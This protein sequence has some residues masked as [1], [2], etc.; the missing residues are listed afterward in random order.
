M[1]TRLDVSA[2]A[3]WEMRRS[4]EVIKTPLEHPIYQISGAVRPFSWR[5]CSR[6]G[7]RLVSDPCGPVACA[8]CRSRDTRLSRHG[9]HFLILR[10]LQR[11]KVFNVHAFTSHI[12]RTPSPRITP[13]T[14]V[15]PI[16]CTPQL[17]TFTSNKRLAHELC[18]CYTCSIIGESNWEQEKDCTSYRECFFSL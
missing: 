15:L 14:T 12:H 3:T 4:A 17:L 9:G 11:P 1:N 16:D 5:V 13:C 7:D 18:S 8:R 6:C 10:T 2:R